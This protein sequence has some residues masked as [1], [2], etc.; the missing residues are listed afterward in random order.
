VFDWDAE[1][2]DDAMGQFLIPLTRELLHVCRRRKAGEDDATA[3]Q[4]ELWYNLSGDDNLGRPAKGR[5]RVSFEFI[6]LDGSVTSVQHY[7]KQLSLRG[8]LDMAE[9]TQAEQ[10]Q[11]NSAKVRTHNPLDGE[12]EHDEVRYRDEL[13]RADRFSD[14]IKDWLWKTGREKETWEKME[15]FYVPQGMT[16]KPWELNAATFNHQFEDMKVYMA[17]KEVEDSKNFTAR[18]MR[19]LEKAREKEERR[20]EYDPD[21]FFRPGTASSAASAASETSVGSA[22]STGNT[23]QLQRELMKKDAWNRYTKDELRDFCRKDFEFESN[24]V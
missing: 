5:V 15:V 23:A 11:K 22:S 16:N 9:M 13:Q 18:K 2:E 3:S 24:E 19:A 14:G 4:R 1:G 20:A 7:I 8:W 10:Q 21:G 12:W 6:P 17:K